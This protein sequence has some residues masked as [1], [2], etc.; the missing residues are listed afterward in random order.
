MLPPFILPALLPSSD[1]TIFS[2]H[3]FVLGAISPWRR[4]LIDFWRVVPTPGSDTTSIDEFVP[5][6]I[7]PRGCCFP[8]FRS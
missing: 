6:A 3:K 2:I 1:S 5:T 4:C 7:F 8:P